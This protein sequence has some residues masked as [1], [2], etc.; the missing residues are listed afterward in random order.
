VSW[1][2]RLWA[3]ATSFTAIPPRRWKT[4]LVALDG[5]QVVGTRTKRSAARGD[6]VVI[7]VAAI[8]E[9]SHLAVRP[10]ALRIAELLLRGG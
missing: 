6:R 2:P 3:R 5:A 4:G 10:E 9:I 1:S 8:P 7:E